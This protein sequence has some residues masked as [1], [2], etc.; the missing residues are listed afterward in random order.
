MGRFTKTLVQIFLSNTT[1]PASLPSS[2]TASRTL[3]TTSVSPQWLEFVFGEAMSEPGGGPS[4]GISSGDALRLP[5][6]RRDRDLWRCRHRSPAG[7]RSHDQ[8]HERTSER[9]IEIQPAIDGGRSSEAKAFSQAC[10]TTQRNRQS[11]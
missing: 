4:S 10:S 11:Q 1:R 8:G 6:R 5:E 3:D 7:L 2:L 9:R